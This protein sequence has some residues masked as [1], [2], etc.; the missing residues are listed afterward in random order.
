MNTER[1]TI[2]VSKNLY[3]FLETYQEK[4][5]YKSR[6]EVVAKALRLLQQ[7]QLEACYREA[8]NEV[9]EAFEITAHDGLEDETW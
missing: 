9:D 6:S 1:F 8:N 2:S 5:H 4:Y 3:H 7:A